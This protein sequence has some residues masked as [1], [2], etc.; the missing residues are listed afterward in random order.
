[1]PIR[2]AVLKVVQNL[3]PDAINIQSRIVQVDGGNKK[4]IAYEYVVSWDFSGEELHNSILEMPYDNI[5]YPSLQAF[6]NS[7]HLEKNIE[8]DQDEHYAERMFL[9]KSFLPVF[10]LSGLSVIEP[11]FAFQELAE[12]G[13]RRRMD[14]VLFGEKPYAIEVRG[15]T[16]HDNSK[17]SAECFED[18]AQRTRSISDLGFIHY[19]FTFENIQQ[20]RAKAK[21]RELAQNDSILG[22]IAVSNEKNNN[23]SS[24]FNIAALLVSFPNY[25]I[26][27]RL[28]LCISFG[29]Q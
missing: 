18:D 20:R 14:F 9:E 16:Y 12:K 5:Q 8:N 1:M 28:Q 17:I 26:Y 6:I 3:D 23:Q 7:H 15:R 4:P 13:K 25:F 27:I 10:G 24:M 29:Q 11:Q 19:P 21:L 2:T 22:R